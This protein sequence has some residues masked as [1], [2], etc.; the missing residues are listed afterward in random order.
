VSAWFISSPQENKSEQMVPA[1]PTL[2]RSSQ[3]MRTQYQEQ[4]QPRRYDRFGVFLGISA[5]LPGP[6]ACRLTQVLQI[7]R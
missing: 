7:C 3:A 2:L 4:R 1:D 5:A 6:S